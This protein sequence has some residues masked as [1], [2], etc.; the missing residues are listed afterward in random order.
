M[1]GLQIVGGQVGKVMTAR[2]R[3]SVTYPPFNVGPGDGAVEFVP[4]VL[5]PL[6]LVVPLV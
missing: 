4:L 3:G 5:A 1:R 6:E 2:K